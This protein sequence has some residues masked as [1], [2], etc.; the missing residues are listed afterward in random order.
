MTR[1]VLIALFVLGGCAEI[2]SALESAAHYKAQANDAQARIWAAS[3][4]DLSLGGMDQLTPQLRTALINICLGI[5]VLSPQPQVAIPIIQPAIE[6]G[7]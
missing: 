1:A 7:P 2:N 3:A 4:C 5:D 6:V